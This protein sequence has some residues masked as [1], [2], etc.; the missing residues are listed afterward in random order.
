MSAQPHESR[1]MT[2]EAYFA[3]C[4][5]SDIRYEYVNGEVFAMTGAT[6]RHNTII[7]N[8]DRAIGNQLEDEDCIVNT[9]E[10]RVQVE[11][12]SDVTY[13]FPDVIIVCGRVE[14]MAK[15]VDTILNPTVLVEVLSPST[16]IVDRNQKFDEYTQ[17]PSLEEYV[18]VSQ[19]EFKEERFLR[20]KGND[21]L[22]TR[23][24][25]LEGVI[26]LPSIGCKLN[27]SNVY[28]KL[29]LLPDEQ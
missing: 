1:Y 17:L 18:L 4:D 7:H 22:Y 8:I 2:E 13:R 23:V 6:V 29:D 20:Q 21:W 3:L 25:G 16:A 24:T 12:N 5:E 11:S 15:R 26:A 27:L 9:N 28:A 14:Y 10:T 19:D